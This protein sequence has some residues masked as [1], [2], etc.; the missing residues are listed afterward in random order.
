[1]SLKLGTFLFK[2]DFDMKKTT[3]TTLL[4][5]TVLFAAPALADEGRIPIHKVTT[6][7]KAGSYVVTRDI[8]DATTNPIISVQADDVTIDLNGN[9]ITGGADN[10]LIDFSDHVNVTIKNGRLIGGDF[11]IRHSSTTVFTRAAFENLTILDTVQSAET[12]SGAGIYVYGAEFVEAVGCRVRN[13][14]S[15]GIQVNGVAPA[16]STFG[17]R[18]IANTTHETQA[19]GISCNGL[20]GGEIRGN[21]VFKAR[22][23]VV[24]CNESS[25]AAGIQVYGIAFVPTGGNIIE[26]NTVRDSKCIGIVTSYSRGNVIRNNVVTGSVLHGIETWFDPADPTARN[27]IE[28][29][30]CDANG[31]YGLWLGHTSDYYKDNKLLENTAGAVT[32]GTDGGGNIL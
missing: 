11:G 20:R 31:G 6:S 17:G 5:L 19:A 13:S 25:G 15:T 4:T 14:G 3:L 9:S 22:Q 8:A 18:F 12:Y 7:T 32:G 27:L 10:V 29:N 30:L 24:T 2:G 21:Q 26:D 16:N 1:M 28:G 23:G